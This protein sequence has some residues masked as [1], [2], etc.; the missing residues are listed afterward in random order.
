[1]NNNH[2]EVILEHLLSQKKAGKPIVGIYCCFAPVELIRA[3]G[4]VHVGLCAFSND[5]I[6][7]AEAVL[8][9][10]LCPLIKASYGYIIKKTCPFFELSD[11]IVGETTC[12]GKKK[13]FELIGNRKHV[14][15][16][17]LPQMPHDKDA[18]DHWKREVVKFRTF[19]E[20]TFRKE[21]TNKS[22]ESAISFL[23]R[24]RR[25][26]LKLYEFCKD[27]PPVVKGSELNGLFGAAFAGD[28]YDAELEKV[29]HELEARHAERK[30]IASRG[31]PRVLLTGSPLLGDAAK[32]IRVIEE[33]GG[34]VVV[35]EACSGIKP[36][37]DMVEE[38]TPDP[39]DAIVRRYF[40]LPCS[41]MT[42]NTRRL[43]LLDTLIEEFKPDCVIEIV[44]VA[45]HTYNVES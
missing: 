33:S 26:K 28:D 31:A 19:L 24:Q 37:L 14:H 29:I 42:P 12:D 22:L 18:Y 23:N 5:P 11:A 21:I 30:F 17:E 13:M 15:I 44:L 4:G 1:M 8:P 45:C 43:E 2:R 3:I 41:C 34:V 6:A 40:R 38:G 16:L 32:V 9:S 25:Q 10:N 36:I 35:H 27:I 20:D 7:A 39:L